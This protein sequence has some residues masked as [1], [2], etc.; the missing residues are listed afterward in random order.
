MA[1]IR[2]HVTG[3][4][5]QDFEDAVKSGRAYSVGSG[6]QTASTGDYLKVVFKNPVG[7]G[8]KYFIFLR[9]FS[10]DTNSA[11]LQAGLVISPTAIT[12]PTTVTG[13]NLLTGGPASAA[14]FTYKV[15]NSVLG[16]AVLTTALPINGI[17]SEIYTLRILAE[18]QSFG[19]QVE[20]VGGGGVGSQSRIA[21]S[22]IW[23][24]ELDN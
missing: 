13:N 23:F 9:R 21:A 3:S 4:P 17:P 14:E 1:T 10:S 11:I 18:G 15:E 16:T 20:G 24:E 7:S 6:V 2:P 22:I 8:K 19:Y 5:Y 12:S